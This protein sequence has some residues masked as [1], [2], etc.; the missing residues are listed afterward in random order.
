[1]SGLSVDDAREVLARTPQVLERLLGGV[2]AG[3]THAAPAGAWTPAKILTHLI[4][5]ERTDWVPRARIIL[6]E[7]E[8]R[9][10]DP[11]D[12]EGGADEAERP[13]EELLAEL[14]G[15]R[16][17]NLRYLDGLDLDDEA[18]AR[19]GTHPELGSVT[20]E[21]LIATWAAHDLGHVGHVVEVMSKRYRQEVGP[22]RAFLPFLDRPD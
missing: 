1:M 17:E 11:F 12:R 16:S 14:A 10:F 9:P 5:G 3:W 8:S 15:L 4:H 7:G 18:L 22:W 19:R 13:I 20:L 2:S 21:Q 6:E